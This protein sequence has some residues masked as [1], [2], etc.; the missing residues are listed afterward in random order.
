MSEFR[1]FVVPYDF[2]PHAVAALAAARD[3]AQRLDADLHLLHV[4]H[5]PMQ[6]YAYAPHPAAVGR[7]PFDTHELREEARGALEKV[8]EQ[9]VG[10][11]RRAQ[12]HVVEGVGIADAIRLA[13]EEQGAD[14]IVMGTHGRTG[15]AHV[16]LG[17]V[18]ERTL[19]LAPC[20]VLTVRA[21]EEA[22]ED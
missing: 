14:L 8:A 6:A 17:S 4:V 11:P 10:L 21:P 1:T 13:A 19:R 5:I 15:L 3:L 16:F 20:P 9:L 12:A 18:A 2:S 7:I 22:E